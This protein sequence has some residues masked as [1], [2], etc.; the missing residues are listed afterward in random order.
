M[1]GSIIF[2]NGASSSGKTTLAKE[3]QRTLPLAFWHFSIDHIRDAGVLPSARIRAGE[4]QWATMRA[5]FFDGFHGCVPVLAE[6]GNNLIVEH[7]IDSQAWMDRLAVLIG[8][9][10]VFCVG[11]QC[12]LAELE[13]REHARGDRPLGDAKRDH[14][15]VHQYCAYD[16]EV[17]G[18][19]PREQA[20]GAV[21]EAWDQRA[22]PSAFAQMKQSVPASPRRG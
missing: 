6:A 17:D 14:R 3:L 21:I 11:V 12:P 20:A 18:T 2:I 9:L 7:I 5:A 8:H 15:V 13:R 1:A 4:F 16:L 22:Q 10:D 19:M